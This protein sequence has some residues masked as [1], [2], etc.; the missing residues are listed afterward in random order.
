MKFNQGDEVVVVIDGEACAIRTVRLAN[1][2][3]VWIT[4]DTGRRFRQDS[5]YAAARGGFTVAHI[6]HATQEHRDTIRSG[7]LVAKLK[8]TDFHRLPLPVLEE[9]WAAVERATEP[10]K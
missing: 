8:L 2:R 7:V 3:H 1:E 10:S 6:K 9:M 4:G 5:G